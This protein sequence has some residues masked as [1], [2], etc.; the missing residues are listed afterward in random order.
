MKVSKARH[1]VNRDVS[2]SLK[3]MAVEEGNTAAMTTSWFIEIVNKWFEIMTNRK[4]LLALRR[5]NVRVYEETITFLND[6]IKLFEELQVKNPNG[7]TSWKP[8]QT[9][10]I[11]STSSI[12]HLQDTFLS[13]KKYE[14]LLSRFTQE[15]LGNLFSV[16]RLKQ[17]IPKPLQFKNNLKLVCVSQYLKCTS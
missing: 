4:T 8:I 3:F 2:C 1:V 16:L 6:V 14:Y 5:S 7:K 13:Q 17:V 12:L 11:L 15:C 10:V 9:G